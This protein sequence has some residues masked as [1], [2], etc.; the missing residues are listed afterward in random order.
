MKDVINS[1]VAGKSLAIAGVSRDPMKW[2]NSLYRAIRKKGYSIVPVN[3]NAENINGQKC[4]SAVSQIPDKIE[5][6]IITLPSEKVIPVLKDCIKAKVKR[7]WLHQGGGTGAYSSE[8]VQYCKDN[9]LELVYGV[10]PM[11]FFPQPGPHKI[12]YFF[13]KLFG[14]LPVEL[15][16]D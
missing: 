3:P 14:T 1:F 15:K 16:T 5:N 12:H 6:V 2:G 10:C 8:A 9:K 7:V 13:K 4:Y 11:M